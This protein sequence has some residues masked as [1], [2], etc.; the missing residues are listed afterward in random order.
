MGEGGIGVGDDDVGGDALT[1]GQGDAGGGT[2]LHQDARDLR[3]A[4]ERPALP[5]D[6]PGQPVHQAAGAAER[7]MHAPAPFEMGDEAVDR[8]RPE[9]AAADEERVEAEDRSQALVA[10][11]ARHHVVDAVVPAETHE[12]GH[13]PQHVGDRAERHVAE[14]LEPDLADRPRALHEAFVAGHVPGRE[15]RD[16]FAHG[17]EIAAVI[18]GR[19]VLEADAVERQHRREDDIVLHA[20]PAQGPEFLEQERRGDDGRPGIEGEPVLAMHPRPP[21]GLVQPLQHRDPVAPRPEADGG[22]ESSEAAADHHRM[23]ASGRPGRGHRHIAECQHKV[24]LSAEKSPTQAL[25]HRRS[26]IARDGKVPAAVG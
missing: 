9:R 8:A 5:P 21:A 14:P 19:A 11:V 10:D 16:L 17:V 13:D 23:G 6:Q 1:R 18:E 22:G 24:T 3:A 26:V 2:V 20:P 7:E 25:I 12:I 4:A 15:P